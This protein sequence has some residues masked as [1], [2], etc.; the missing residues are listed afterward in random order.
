MKVSPHASR[1]LV[2]AAAVP[3]LLWAILIAH[4]AALVMIVLLAGAGAW[5]EYFTGFVSRE[6]PVFMSL[7]LVGWIL[8]VLG[9]ALFGGPGQLA[10][11]TAAL[12]LGAGYFL[13]RYGR[14][15]LS[16]E[17]LGPF[18]LGHLYISLLLSTLV[19]TAALTKRAVSGFCLSC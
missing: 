12:A 5:W 17:V 19:M 2:A 18:A 16:L 14:Q 8:T 4:P 1:W 11:L 7:A 10:G 6:Q 3:I 13:W 15:P 9:A